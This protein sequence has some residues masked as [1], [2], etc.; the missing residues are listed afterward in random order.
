MLIKRIKFTVKTI[1]IFLTLF[2]HN[3]LMANFSN[4]DQILNKSDI[5]NLT[6][7][8]CQTTAVADC[9][10]SEEIT[11]NGPYRQWWIKYKPTVVF[12]DYCLAYTDNHSVSDIEFSRDTTFEIG[13]VLDGS[14]VNLTP[15]KPPKSYQGISVD[16]VSFFMDKKDDIELSS[17]NGIKFSKCDRINKLKL[18][19]VKIYS[20]SIYLGDSRDPVYELSVFES[21]SDELYRVYYTLKTQEEVCL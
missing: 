19:D 3:T 8:I 7:G 17:K 16:L 5:S 2:A 4:Q 11:T 9:G 6:N 13:R 14:C 15:Y 18:V 1:L 12:S 21:E 20:T 10:G